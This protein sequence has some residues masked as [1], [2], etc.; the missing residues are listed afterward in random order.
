MAIKVLVIDDD[1]NIG[2]LVASLLDEGPYQV[3]YCSEPK[4]GAQ[5]LIAQDHDIYLIDQ[6]LGQ[7]Y[8]GIEIIQTAKARGCQKPMI[9]LTSDGNPEIDRAAS[10]AFA[11]DFLSKSTLGAELERAI[12]FAYGR[13]MEQEQLFHARRKGSLLIV[14]DDRQSRL[15]LRKILGLDGAGYHLIEAEDGKAG[16]Q[17][18]ERNFPDLVLLDVI[19][20]GMD[21]YETCAHLKQ[22]ERLRGIPVIFL[23]AADDTVKGLKAGGAD[24][25][26]K[27]FS[28]NELLARVQIQLHLAKLHRETME[29]A[30]QAGMATVAHDIQHN[31]GNLANTLKI[32]LETIDQWTRSES[33]SRLKKAL[34][35]L[36]DHAGSTQSLMS[37]LTTKKGSLL[38]AFL[39]Q[40]SETVQDDFSE[41]HEEAT[42]AIECVIKIQDFL[43]DQSQYKALPHGGTTRVFLR[44][45]IKD[46]IEDLGLKAVA[47]LEGDDLPALEI[48]KNLID[49]VFRILLVNAAEAVKKQ[50]SPI[51]SIAFVH[52]NLFQSVVI[53]DNGCGIPS[54]NLKKIFSYGF[55]TWRKKG[56]GLHTLA[57]R[58][59]E[60]GGNCAVHSKG[61]GQ[62]SSFKCTFPIAPTKKKPSNWL[63]PVKIDY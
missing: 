27:P 6:N 42:R 17:C 9:L 32:S 56:F 16:I 46:I 2:A 38:M 28:Q 19:M 3:S 4:Q 8:Y 13:F 14:D 33:V 52:E 49:Q 34:R 31:M 40:L 35:M 41:V 53:R 62:G 12:R 36:S 22:S 54:E 60:L 55:S 24:Y 37:F 26:H 39:A 44:M 47:H 15:I 1:E 23:S 7:G 51:I 30:H 45:C 43:V 25:I 20:P 63:S 50:S 59:T 48:N 58:M 29:F 21:G 10:R 57:N 18:A 11:S 61:F 5:A